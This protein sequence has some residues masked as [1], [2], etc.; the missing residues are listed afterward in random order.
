M[1]GI[2]I[3]ALQFEV[4]PSAPGGTYLIVWPDQ[5]GNG[6]YT[7]PAHPDK[8]MLDVQAGDIVVHQ[9]KTQ[10]RVKRLRPYRTSECKSQ[11]DYPWITSARDYLRQRSA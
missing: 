10:F 9:R 2:E 7:Q 1:N 3:Y 8:T 4:E 11:D 6:Q 5:T